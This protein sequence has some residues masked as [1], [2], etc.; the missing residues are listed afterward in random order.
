MTQS[1]RTF[2]SHSCKDSPLPQD[3]CQ[4]DRETNNTAQCGNSPSDTQT[5]SS[6]DSPRKSPDTSPAD[7][8]D[9]QPYRD[10]N[11]LREVYKQEE[12]ITGTAAHFDISAMTARTWL[13]HH[14]IFD[15]DI[16][17][18]AMPH[19]RLKELDPEDVD[20][21]GGGDQ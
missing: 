12:T 1:N 6:H 3:Y 10:P 7:G 9:Q 19:E 11:Q 16:D 17:G 21:S 18:L 14:D 2:E 15:P 4:G 8:Y 13:I 5:S 20:I